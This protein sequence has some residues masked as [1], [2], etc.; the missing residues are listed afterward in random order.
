MYQVVFHSRDFPGSRRLLYSR[1]PGKLVRDS[2]EYDL[3]SKLL[4]FSGISGI[5]HQM[6]RICLKS[7]IMFMK[8]LV[9]SLGAPYSVN[10][11][12]IL[13][14]RKWPDSSFIKKK[15]I[16]WIPGNP[17]KLYFHSHFPGNGKIAFPWKH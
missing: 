4:Y 11:Y 2:R 6:L 9:R 7:T 10:Q 3:L 12:C 5:F 16:P 15:S 14:F 8:Y 17:G 1:F 13:F